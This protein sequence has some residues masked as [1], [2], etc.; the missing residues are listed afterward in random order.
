MFQPYEH[1]NSLKKN[2]KTHIVYFEKE[3]WSD[4]EYWT[5]DRVLSNKH[6]HQK[7]YRKYKTKTSPRPLS[8]IGI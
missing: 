1:I 2:L 8:N 6:F 4:I 7:V 3:T 5:T